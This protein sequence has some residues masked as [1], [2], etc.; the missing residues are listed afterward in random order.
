MSVKFLKYSIDFINLLWILNLPLIVV[1]LQDD[2]ENK[3]V[4][5][6]YHVC[7]ISMSSFLHFI[8]YFF[9]KKIN[10]IEKENINLEE[11]NVFLSLINFFPLSSTSS[12]FS[13][14][15]SVDKSP[16]NKLFGD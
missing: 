10:K 6:F 2:K 9:F 7:F 15:F 14:N 11:V 12:G 5:T 16:Y 3:I 13:H 1:I 4:L 8:S